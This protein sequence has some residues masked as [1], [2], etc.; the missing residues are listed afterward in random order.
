MKIA[1][2]TV[3]E[4]WRTILLILKETTTLDQLIS[5]IDYK[6]VTA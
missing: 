1:V 2:N 3:S 6:T 4:A 5:S